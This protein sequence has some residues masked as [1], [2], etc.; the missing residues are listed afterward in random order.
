MPYARIATFSEKRISN[1]L[2]RS[3]FNLLIIKFISITPRQAFQ[4]K[5]KPL[6][7]MAF[8]PFHKSPYL[9]D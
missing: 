7:K 5:V 1:T 2:S 4:L 9:K 8:L 6:H 3:S